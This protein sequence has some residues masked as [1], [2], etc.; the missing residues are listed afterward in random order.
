MKY[1]IVP[2]VL[3]VIEVGFVLDG[4]EVSWDKVVYRISTVEVAV[5]RPPKLKI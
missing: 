4:V 3:K 1:N 5:R 2:I